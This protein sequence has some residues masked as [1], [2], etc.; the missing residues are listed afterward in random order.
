MQEKYNPDSPDDPYEKFLKHIH[1]NKGKEYS[2]QIRASAEGELE[3]GKKSDYFVDKGEPDKEEKFKNDP[4]GELFETNLN[5]EELEKKIEELKK[6][7]EEIISFL[8]NP[9]VEGLTIT[10]K[11][12][13]LDLAEKSEDEKLMEAISILGKYDFDAYT[14]LFDLPEKIKEEIQK[15]TLILEYLERR[16]STG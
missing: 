7:R 14:T 12:S 6:I 11:T 10:Q 16:A 2:D 13:L 1:E 5:K 3:L 4:E 15:D 9:N 8:E